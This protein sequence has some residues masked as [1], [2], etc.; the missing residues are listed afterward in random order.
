MYKYNLHDGITVGSR[1][2]YARELYIGIQQVY[3]CIFH[4]PSRESDDAHII[5]GHDTS[6]FPCNKI[7]KGRLI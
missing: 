2:T 4:M 3:A 5:T 7:I 1:G 6:I